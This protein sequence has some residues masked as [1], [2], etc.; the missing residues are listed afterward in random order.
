[1]RPVVAQVHDVILVEKVNS[2]ISIFITKKCM[3]VAHNFLGP[4]FWWL[5]GVEQF[6]GNTENFETKKLQASTAISGHS[7]SILKREF[8]SCNTP[9]NTG[10]TLLE[11]API[12]NFAQR[13]FFL[14]SAIRIHMSTKNDIPVIEANDS[15]V[16]PYIMSAIQIDAPADNKIIVNFISSVFW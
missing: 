14:M 5:D 8:F 12:F 13:F 2:T 10:F 1:M 9:D 11:L 15:D 4:T 7:F 6:I 3:Q 16:D